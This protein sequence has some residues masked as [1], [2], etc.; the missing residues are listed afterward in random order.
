MFKFV[1]ILQGWRRNASLPEVTVG[2]PDQTAI[3]SPSRKANE[4]Q[5]AALQKPRRI[6]P[7]E[8]CRTGMVDIGS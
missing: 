8:V 3:E 1:E 4:S 5:G 6:Y 7:L 2:K